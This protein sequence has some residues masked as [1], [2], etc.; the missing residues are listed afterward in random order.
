MKLPNGVATPHSTVKRLT[1]KATLYT[2]LALCEGNPPGQRTVFLWYMKSR[3]S[4]VIIWNWSKLAWTWDFKCLTCSWNLLFF[5]HELLCYPIRIFYAIFIFII[6]G[7]T[8]KVTGAHCTEFEAHQSWAELKLLWVILIVNYFSS[9][10]FYFFLA[11]CVDVILWCEMYR[12]AVKHDLGTAILL[13]YSEIWWSPVES[14]HKGPVIRSLD[15]FF[16]LGQNKLFKKQSSCQWFQTPWRVCHV[17]DPLIM[18][19]LWYT[20]QEATSLTN[21]NIVILGH[22]LLI[23]SRPGCVCKGHII[24]LLSMNTQDMVSS[25]PLYTGINVAYWHNMAT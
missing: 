11:V 16:V 8:L 24:I 18:F 15:A 10:N 20:C 7:P 9:Q 1:W 14:P 25:E 12:V 4:R 13:F 3:V 17:S 19:W 22:P 2:L 6:T 21:W 5:T 23:A